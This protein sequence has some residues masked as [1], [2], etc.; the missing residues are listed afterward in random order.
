MGK[1]RVLMYHKVDEEVRDFLTVGRAQLAQHMAYL[2]EHYAVIRLSDVIEHVRTGSTLPERAA[3]VTFDDGYENN[4]SLAYPVF[5]ELGLPF[6][7][8][9]VADFIGKTVMYDGAEQAFMSAEQLKAISDLAEFGYHG[10]KHDNLM[11]L[12]EQEWEREI[13]SCVAKFKSSGIPVQG[14]WAY[15]YGSFPKRD[16]RKLKEFGVLCG[17]HG[18]SCAF[19]IGNGLNQ[20]PL[21]HPFVIERIDIRGGMTFAGFK[22]RLRYGKIF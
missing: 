8:F 18:I 1:L 21:R 13:G 9:P 3:L 16:G 12:A 14:A 19:R 6:A 20:V 4:Y 5:K 17:Q 2:K 15:T 10:F 7:V 11:E 22:R